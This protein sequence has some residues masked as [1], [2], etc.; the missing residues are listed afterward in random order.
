MFTEFG[1]GVMLLTEVNYRHVI[2]DSLMIPSCSSST[3]IQL[4]DVL[5]MRI[6]FSQSMSQEITLQERH[7]QGVIFNLF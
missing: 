7:T 2:N 3:D 5:F 1:D 4:T 6:L